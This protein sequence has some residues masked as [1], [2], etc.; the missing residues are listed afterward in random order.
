MKTYVT[1]FNGADVV[2]CDDD[3]DDEFSNPNCGLRKDGTCVFAH[4]HYCRNVCEHGNAGGP[5]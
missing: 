1:D 5:G 4:T 3:P 2:A